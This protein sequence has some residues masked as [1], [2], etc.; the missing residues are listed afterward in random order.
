MDESYLAGAEI[1]Y[2]GAMNKLEHFNGV[3][4]MSTPFYYIKWQAYLATNP[5]VC[6]KQTKKIAFYK[7]SYK[8]S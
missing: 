1:G 5:W 2:F 4:F 6:K 8:K 7:N 3:V